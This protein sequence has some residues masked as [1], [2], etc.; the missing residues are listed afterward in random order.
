MAKLMDLFKK[1]IDLIFF[2]LFILSIPLEKRHVFNAESVTWHGNFFEW[3]ALSLYLSDILLG[4]TLLFWLLKGFAF[5]L[6]AAESDQPI[7][8]QKIR[9]RGL[10]ALLLAFITVAFLSTIRSDISEISFYHLFKICEGGLLFLYIIKN[11]STIANFL[12]SAAC[13]VA[14]AL[15]Q[16]TLG[17]L[18][19][20]LQRSVGLKILG[21]VDLSPTLSNVAKIEVFGEKLIRAYGTMPHA[22]LL[23]GFLFVGLIFTA[24]FILILALNKEIKA[25]VPRGTFIQKSVDKMFHVEHFG[26]NNKH[27]PKKILRTA[28]Y[29]FCILYLSFVLSFS[30][31]AYL[32]LLVAP[33]IFVIVTILINRRYLGNI[34]HVIKTI[35]G[36]YKKYAIIFTLFIVILTLAFS[37]HII[38]KT[39]TGQAADYSIQGRMWY[40]GLAFNM[41]GDNPDFG[42]GPGM[43]TYNIDKYRD[44][45]STIEW[46][47]YQPVHN[48]ILLIGAE[49]GVTGMLLFTIFIGWLVA[50]AIMNFRKKDAIGKL[51]LGASLTSLFGLIIIMQFDHY[52][53]TLQQGN[54][55]LWI[56]I[57]LTATA[58]TK[59]EKLY[60]PRNLRETKANT[61]P[62]TKN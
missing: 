29:L 54:L 36:R 58:S 25:D 22:N 52:L 62:N 26:K 17:I 20:F 24:L 12:K 43:F 53:W 49:I 51:L 34:K 48:V 27:H 2:Y 4:L 15:F 45:T 46:W 5:K 6:Q 57:G 56:L 13:L 11:I 50:L 33:L 39:S 3:G 37:P 41:I 61:P 38:S 31:S 16:A 19:Y 40:T 1:N 42:V 47:Q 23:G 35:R 30:R 28:L 55:L 18:Q 60:K 10:L 7:P 9:V 8:Y 32:A 59:L 14:A 44:M 21:E